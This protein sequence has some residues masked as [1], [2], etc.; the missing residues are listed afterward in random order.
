MGYRGRLIWPFV[1]RIAP[2]DRAATAADPDGLD[3]LET[4]YDHDFREPRQLP[5]EALQQGRDAR[6]EGEHVDLPCQIEDMAWEQLRMM[7][8]GPAPQ[9]EMVLVFHFAMF[10]MR[11]LVDHM[12]IATVPRIGDRIVSVHRQIDLS[13]VEEVPNPPGLFCEEAIPRSHGLSGLHRNLL[14]CTFRERSKAS[15]RS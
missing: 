3:V 4:G 5:D 6:V 11:G 2:L 1:V 10:E 7:R 12:G 13:L 9:F 15:E 8:S 14:V